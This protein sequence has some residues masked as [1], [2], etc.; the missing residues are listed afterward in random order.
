M[1]VIAQDRVTCP[2]SNEPS[3]CFSRTC[4]LFQSPGILQKFIRY[5]LFYDDGYFQI[6]IPL[7]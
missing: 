6:K 3:V 5:P 2:G 7:K 4:P 1:R